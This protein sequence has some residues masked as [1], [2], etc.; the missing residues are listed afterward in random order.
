M[1][2]GHS[3][4]LLLYL[5]AYS[6]TPIDICVY[7][8]KHLYIWYLLWSSTL[9]W[10]PQAINFWLIVGNCRCRWMD[11]HSRNGNAH[12]LT[13]NDNKRSFKLMNKKCNVALRSADSYGIYLL[14]EHVY[15]F[16]DFID[17]ITLS[18]VEF[19]LRLPKLSYTLL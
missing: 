12:L 13:L 19:L 16:Y 14:V 17:V 2:L 15:T 5:H 1:A 18:H 11:W 4:C 3:L 8:H 10:R 6:H 9:Y 7:T